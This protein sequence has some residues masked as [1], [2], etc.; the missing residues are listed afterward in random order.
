MSQATLNELSL[1]PHIST[2]LNKIPKATLDGASTKLDT[3]P[4][5][6]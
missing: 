1:I 6:N 2:E 4:K 5:F 3:L